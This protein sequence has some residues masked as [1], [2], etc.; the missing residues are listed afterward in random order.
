MIPVK[1]TKVKSIVNGNKKTLKVLYEN[2]RYPEYITK[3]VK[4]FFHDTYIHKPNITRKA[5]IV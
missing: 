5:M 2:V 1:T 3:K 4:N